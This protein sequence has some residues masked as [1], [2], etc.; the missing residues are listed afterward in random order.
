MALQKRFNFGRAGGLFNQKT[1][2]R[3]LTKFHMD[4]TE[5]QLKAAKD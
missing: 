4:P 3:A 1:I 5:Q 2:Q